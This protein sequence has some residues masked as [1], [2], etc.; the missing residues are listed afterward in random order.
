MSKDVSYHRSAIQYNDE[1]TTFAAD[2]AER[3]EHE[4]VKKWCRSIAKQHEFH[5][6]RHKKALSKLEENSG[7]GSGNSEND[8]P[9]PTP[10]PGDPSPSAE[11]VE[12]TPDPEKSADPV[13]AGVR[14]PVSSPDDELSV[15]DNPR[16]ELSFQTA[17]AAGLNEE[18]IA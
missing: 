12:S 17:A 1:F 18:Q 14:T 8:D 7:D 11:P 3:V 4:E 5:S 13:D 9:T 6:G 16:E 2:L 15:A 10:A